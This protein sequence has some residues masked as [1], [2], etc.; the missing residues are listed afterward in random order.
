MS[1]N[2]LTMDYRKAANII[3]TAG[4]I[5]FAVTDTLMEIIRFYLDDDDVDFIVH[6]FDRGKTLSH[7]QLRTKSGLSDESI[8]AKTSK[9]ARKG[10]LFNQPNTQGEMVYRLLPLILVGTFEY[11]FMKEL[12]EGDGLEDYRKIA[13]LYHKLLEE[14][15]DNIQRGYDNLLPIFENQP[16]IDRTVPVFTS[17]TGQSINI[18]VNEAIDAV[19]QV[20]PARTVEEIIG[21]FDDIAVGHCF[22]R[23]YNRVLGHDCEIHAPSEVCFTFG[24]SAR[25][26]I[27]QGFARRVDRQE[28]LNIM[29]D[30]EEAGLV[31]K[32]FHNGSNISKEENSICN[33][34]K[35]CCDTF[36]LWRNGAAPMVN[37]TYYLSVIHE[38][39]CTG[40]GICVE[41]C[42]VD[43]IVLDDRGIAVR[44]EKYCIGCGICARL[45]PADAI[46]LREGMRR[47]YVPPPRLR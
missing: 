3:A 28:A 27:N 46:S 18:I 16:A 21:K 15:R 17:E 30:A 45:C 29:R 32:A 42:P 19:E 6:T 7:E 2:D 12:P 22:C 44:E 23:N 24:K 11:T 43:A 14:L 4:I 39:R 10:I 34:C 8:E 47:V 13:R 31:H 33:C 35:D 1:G 36:T 9:L 40:C 5:P 41:R 26:T 38:D 25:H 20:L 37:A